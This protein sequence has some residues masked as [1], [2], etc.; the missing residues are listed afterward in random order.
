[1]KRIILILLSAS[2]ALVSA[3]NQI[4]LR[5]SNYSGVNSLELNPSSFSFSPLK[6][7]VNIVSGGLFF[8]ND[9]LYVEN[10]NFFD[11]IGHNGPFLFRSTSPEAIA[12]GDDPDALYYNY[13]D[14]TRRMNNTLNAFVGLPSV[15]FKYKNI[16]LG[17]FINA[18][19]SLG[20]NRLDED[21]DYFSIEQWPE[22]LTKTI[23]PTSIAGMTWSEIGINA[24]LQ[25]Y[26]D[27][28]KEIHVGATVKY[29][30]G[31]EGFYAKSENTSQVTEINDTLLFRGGPYE[32]GVASSSL[33]NSSFNT[34]GNGFG[35]D[36]GINYLAKSFDRRP[37]KYRVGASIIDLGYIHFDENA[38]QHFFT[39][40]DLYDVARNS[41]TQITDLNTLV[42]I[43]SEQAFGND[44]ESL[45]DNEFTLFTPTALSIQFDYAFDPNWY[46][47]G[48][49]NQRLKFSNRM[50]DREN[51]MVV[52][53]RYDSQ[54]FEAGVP[55]TVY[56]MS[57][58]RLG[59]WFRMAFLTVG[60]EHIG[61]L[62]VKEPQFSGADI[63]FAIKINS[64]SRKRKSGPERCNFN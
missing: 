26:E 3:Q 47:G 63:Y 48:V 27:E 54:W 35:L 11:L 36:I 6:W 41:L 46:I 40:S 9:Y 22:G 45:Q 32:Y 58:V 37:Y 34:N 14:A 1:M 21:L 30:M 56:N 18:R 4:G 44:S 13:F 12:S 55:L 31:Y 64:F 43:A 15:A 38:Q 23:D 16:A 60:S 8:E 61:S 28:G 33:G 2:S 5:N 25:V 53:P 17:V 49:V 19:T 7:D 29:L 50:V 39:A 24:G 59:A 62:F 42:N 20:L 52:A 51:I 10:T 57:K